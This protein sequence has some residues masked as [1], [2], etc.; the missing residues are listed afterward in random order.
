MSLFVLD[1]RGSEVLLIILVIQV[2]GEVI[3]GDLALIVGTALH[4]LHGF[5]SLTFRLIF[6]KQITWVCT[7]VF[8]VLC[9]EPVVDHC[10]ELRKPFQ[11]VFF[12]LG[13]LLFGEVICH[14]SSYPVHNSNHC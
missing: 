2:S 10:S 9:H 4:F 5:F 3:E 14:I 1:G 13:P 7:N 8:L 6:D 12:V 11:Q